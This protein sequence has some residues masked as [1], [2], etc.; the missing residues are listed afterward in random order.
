M[1]R[2]VEMFDKGEHVMVEMEITKVELKG[3]THKYSLK[4]CGTEDYLKDKYIADQ[5]IPMEETKCASVTEKATS[6]S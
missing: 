6:E 4:V 3:A 5:L 2:M 1:S